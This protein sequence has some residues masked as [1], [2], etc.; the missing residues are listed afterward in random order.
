MKKVLAIVAAVAAMA[1]MQTAASDEGTA[2]GE[3]QTVQV[4]GE[5]Q[6]SG[7]GSMVYGESLDDGLGTMVYG[8]KLDSGLGE[9]TVQDLQQYLPPRAVQTAT[10]TR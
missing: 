4:L 10:L 7:L 5:K 9:L 3:E 8:E 6:D 1:M 2:Q